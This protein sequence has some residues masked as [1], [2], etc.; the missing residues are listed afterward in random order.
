MQS[1]FQ[2]LS[3]QYVIEVW[4]GV[5]VICIQENMQLQQS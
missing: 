1:V 4:L 2:H 3:A 5:Q